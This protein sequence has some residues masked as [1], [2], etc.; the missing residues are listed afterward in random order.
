MQRDQSFHDHTLF[1]FVVIVRTFDYLFAFS[2]R[3]DVPTLERRTCVMLL[4]QEWPAG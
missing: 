4:L 2:G 1:S 3:I